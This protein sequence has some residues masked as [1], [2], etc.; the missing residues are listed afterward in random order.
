MSFTYAYP[1]PALT[2]DAV[3]FRESGMLMEVLLIRRKNPPYSGSWALPGGFVEMD[4][5]LEEAVHREL[6]EETGV[7]DLHLRQL[8]AFSTPGRDPRGHTISVVF[9]GVLEKNQ[10]ILAGDDAKEV[11][12]FDLNRLPKL[13]FDHNE[14][15]EVAASRFIA[16]INPEFL[17]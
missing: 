8:Q 3:V 13:A 11:A 14:I 6:F 10:E 9:W 4:E 7:K 16:K 1:R 2:V 15:I 17:P 12:W 5:S